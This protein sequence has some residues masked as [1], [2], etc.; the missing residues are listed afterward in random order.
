MGLF[1]F[2]TGFATGLYAGLYVVKHYDVPNV[3]D[4]SEL[5]EKIKNLAEGYK[6]DK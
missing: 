3:P 4:P 2:V 5:F 1:N 6:K